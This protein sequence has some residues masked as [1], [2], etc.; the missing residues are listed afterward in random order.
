M[1]DAWKTDTV[2]AESTLTA[3]SVAG[4]EIFSD[5]KNLKTA[6]W[7]GFSVDITFDGDNATDDLDL[8][9]YKRIT[10]STF[11]GTEIAKAT[12]TITSDGSVDIYNFEFMPR[13]SGPGYYRYGLVRSGSST[14]FTVTAVCELFRKT[15][16]VG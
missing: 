7:T 2:T 4:T 15:E 11:V 8:K 6:G 12:I 9:L 1:H 5:V 10:D 14:T 3:A 16:G 13:D